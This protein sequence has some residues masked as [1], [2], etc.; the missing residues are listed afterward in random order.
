MRNG[1]LNCSDLR[2]FKQE[3]TDENQLIA[4]AVSGMLPQKGKGIVL[5]VGAGLGDIAACAFPDRRAIL[6]DI[7]DFPDSAVSNHVR[8]HCDFFKYSHTPD[9]PVDLVLL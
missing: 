7:L 5:D 6:L 2:T 3:L 8:A 1:R 4:A 9:I